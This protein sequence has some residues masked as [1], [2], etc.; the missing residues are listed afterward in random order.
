MKKKCNSHTEKC[1]PSCIYQFWDLV[2]SQDY[3]KIICEMSES[4]EMSGLMNLF[5][6]TL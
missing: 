4:L 1:K 6:L 3:I 2:K 5:T